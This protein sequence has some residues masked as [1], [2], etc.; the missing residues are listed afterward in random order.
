MAGNKTKR[1]AVREREPTGYQC[2]ATPTTLFVHGDECQKRLED[3]LIHGRTVVPPAG[4]V[5]SQSRQDASGKGDLDRAVE[6]AGFPV[7]YWDARFGRKGDISNPAALKDPKSK[8]Y[9]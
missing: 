1:G 7:Q 4:L 5:K 9:W 6:L 2:S 3:I 8:T